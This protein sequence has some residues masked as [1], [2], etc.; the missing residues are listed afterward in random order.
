MLNSSLL[1]DCFCFINIGFGYYCILFI[2]VF[3]FIVKEGEILIVENF[4][5]Y[6]YFKV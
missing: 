6:L 3:G 4:E 5:V 1:E 2:I